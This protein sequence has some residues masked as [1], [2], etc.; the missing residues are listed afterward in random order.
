[1]LDT[2]GLHFVRCIKPN[3]AL[4]PGRLEMPLILHQLRCC[5]VLEVARVARAGYPTRYLHSDFVLRYQVMLPAGR[6][7][8]TGSKEALLD[9]CRELLVEFGVRCWPLAAARCPLPAARC[10]L[11]AACCLL[12]AARCPLP[13]GCWLRLGP[14]LHQAETVCR[15]APAW[16]GH[17]CPPP[18]PPHP[19]TP[20]PGR[21]TRRATRSAAPRSSSAPACWRLWRTCGRASRT[22]RCGCR[23]T[24]AC[25]ATARPSC[26]CATRRAPSRCAV[27]AAWG[28]PWCLAPGPTPGSWPYPAPRPAPRP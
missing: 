26:A 23:P 8:Q 7:L 15:S 16:L 6:Q 19:P 28:L 2:T 4:A 20:S 10:L 13:A 18:H 22:R 27:R 12:P 11:P 17:P 21:W 14:A 5:G 1:M 25:M 9:A 3:A 24:G